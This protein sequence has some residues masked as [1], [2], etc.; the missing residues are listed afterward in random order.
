ML[1]PL[2]Y[3]LV[4]LCAVLLLALV[5]RPVWKWLTSIKAHD[6]QL[7]YLQA[8]EAR[9]EAISKNPAPPADPRVV[10]LLTSIDGN[11]K[12]FIG[13]QRRVLRDLHGTAGTDEDD[14]VE[15]AVA[16]HDR[17]PELTIED[18]MKR[19]RTMRTYKAS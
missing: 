4:A 16:M 2:D 19:V 14:I 3:L 5:A 18:C 11:M 13:G 6:R 1:N 9:L 8:I 17:Y 7:E 12:E 15:Q 10:E